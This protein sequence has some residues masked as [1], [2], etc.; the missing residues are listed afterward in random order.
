MYP[1]QNPYQVQ[2]SRFIGFGLPFVG[3]LLGGLLG[4][5]IGVSLLARPFGGYLGYP[6]VGY[7]GVGYPGIGYP[8]FGYP[9][10]GYPGPGGMFYY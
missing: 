5:G 9:G 10:M 3:G 8:G 2:D 4:G 6:A 7:P 1:Y